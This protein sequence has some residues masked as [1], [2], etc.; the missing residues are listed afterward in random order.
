MKTKSNLYKLKMR[1][2]LYTVMCNRKIFT[3]YVRAILKC[4]PLNFISYRSVV[5]IQKVQNIF[6]F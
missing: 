3:I 1:L 6:V 5:A 4:H 2:K